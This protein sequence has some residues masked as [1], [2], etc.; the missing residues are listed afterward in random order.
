MRADFAPGRRD[1][2]VTGWQQDEP[3]MTISAEAIRQSA[4]E[5]VE[6]MG[7]VAIDYM[8]ARIAAAEKDG[9][10]EERDQAWLLLTEIERILEEDKA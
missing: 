9:T 1:G 7:P 8:R 6:R 5:V 10:L 4:R 3:A 2:N